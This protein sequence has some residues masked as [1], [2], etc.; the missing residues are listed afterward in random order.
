MCSAFTELFTLLSLRYCL[1][2]EP[3]IALQV[4]FFRF[5]LFCILQKLMDIIFFALFSYRKQ[6]KSM[7]NHVEQ[8]KDK[9]PV[10]KYKTPV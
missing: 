9:Y 10:N 2:I 1:L 3:D 8:Y 6:M 4:T 7:E 5:I